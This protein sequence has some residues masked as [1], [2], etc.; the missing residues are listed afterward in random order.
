MDISTYFSTGKSSRKSVSLL[1]HDLSTDSARSWLGGFLLCGDERIRTVPV[2]YTF[3][4]NC[5]RSSNP[6]L[7]FYKTDREGRLHK[8]G[9]ETKGFEPS[10]AFRPYLVSSEALSTTQ[11]RLHMSLRSMEIACAI[12]SLSGPTQVSVRKKAVSFSPSSATSPNTDEG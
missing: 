6:V 8:T 4:R 2:Q 7:L 9:A 10:R 1:A 11:P 5:S 3:R 12:P